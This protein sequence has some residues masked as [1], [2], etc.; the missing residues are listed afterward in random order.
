[1]AEA[2]TTWTLAQETKEFVPITVTADAVTVSSFEVAMTTGAARPTTW[3]ACSTVATETGILVGAGTSYPLVLGQKH[4]VWVRF[5]DT[6]E[7]PVTRAFY[8]KVT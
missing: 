8:I 4:T 1:M 2:L 7:I 6:P 3:A 5:T